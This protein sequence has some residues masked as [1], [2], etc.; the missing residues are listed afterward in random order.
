MVL[1]QENNKL[2]DIC[3][4]F[5]T[6]TNMN[7][8][9]IEYISALIYL[10]YH[11]DYSNQTF[12]KIY[13]DRDNY[14]ISD[15]IDKAISD[16]REDIGDEKIFSDVQFSN[17]VFYRKLGEKNILSKTIEKINE[18]CNSFPKKYIAEQYELVL[19]Q[20]AMIGDMKNSNELFYTPMEITNAIKLNDK[21]IKIFGQEENIE[22]YNI[23]KTRILLNDIEDEEIEYQN[24][25][26]NKKIKFDYI[27]SN[28]P[29]SKKDWKEVIKYRPIFEE[30]SRGLCICNIYVRQFK[31]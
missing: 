4:D 3:N 27:L 26:K 9:Y 21:K 5:K 2:T 22:Y 31:R 29:Y 24:N 12:R 19:K 11:E 16:M 20:I 6:K 18:M 7:T 28:P 10:K 17:I 15:K 23:L 25:E 30:C 8:N 13:E 1:F 14:Y